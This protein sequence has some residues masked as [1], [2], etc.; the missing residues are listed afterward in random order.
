MAKQLIGTAVTNENGVATFT[1]TGTGAGKLNIVAESG[2]L[3]SETYEI[4]DYLVYDDGVHS[5]YDKWTATGSPTIV[6]GNEYTEITTNGTTT[7]NVGHSTYISGD[8]EL[9]I[10]MQTPDAIRF[11]FYGGSGK[12]TRLQINA[13]E[14]FNIWKIRRESGVFST[15]VSSNGGQSWTTITYYEQDTV[16]NADCSILFYIP[17]PSGNSRSVKFKNLTVTSI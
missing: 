11:G 15:K 16:G 5:E 12:Y 14:S 10:E 8:F 6:R 4:W 17:V 3:V 2:S 9:L 13:S 7:A 1:Y